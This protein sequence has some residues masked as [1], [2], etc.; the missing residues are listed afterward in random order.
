M[1]TT[2]DRDFEKLEEA[3]DKRNRMSGAAKKALNRAYRQS[4]DSDLERLRRML[5]EAHRKHDLKEIGRL[6]EILYRN[7]GRQRI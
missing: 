6:E 1:K 7:Y 2:R 3:R 4:K 5:V